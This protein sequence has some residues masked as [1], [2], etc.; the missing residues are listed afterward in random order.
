MLAQKEP[1]RIAALNLHTKNGVRLIP[2]QFR[3]SPSSSDPFIPHYSV[4]ISY[5]AHYMVQKGG[6]AIRLR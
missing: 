2:L 4:L 5:P 6:K 1:P 3:W